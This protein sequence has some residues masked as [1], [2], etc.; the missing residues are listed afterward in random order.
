MR[1]DDVGRKGKKLGRRGLNIADSNDRL[2]TAEQE[3]S[4][5][6]RQLSKEARKRCESGQSYNLEALDAIKDALVDDAELLDGLGQAMHPSALTAMH[7]AARK[8]KEWASKLM[9]G[10]G[11]LAKQIADVRE[12]L[13]AVKEQIKEE[14]VSRAKVV[15]WEEAQQ[16]STK[17]ETTLKVHIQELEAK[18]DQAAEEESSDL[19]AANFMLQKN[20]A[21]EK[22]CSDGLVSCLA[23][24]Q[25]KSSRLKRFA[26]GAEEQ[27]GIGIDFES[28]AGVQFPS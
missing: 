14:A 7:G 2:L 21:T 3:F 18:L 13:V 8:A 11:T 20:L 17:L 1:A 9:P 28:G 15:E 6:M 10:L 24:E 5:A 22:A 16:E 12:S 26:S 27:E 23:M 4:R 25:S 19:A